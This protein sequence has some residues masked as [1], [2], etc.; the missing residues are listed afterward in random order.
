MPMFAIHC[1]DRADALPRRLESRPTHLAYL[2]SLAQVRVAGALL[3]EAGDPRGTL[4][5][6]EAEDLAAAQAL[7][8]GDPFQTLGVFERVVV[9]PWRVSVGQL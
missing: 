1:T 5:I 2:Q 3:D 4:V 7:A 8:A 9:Q 6:V